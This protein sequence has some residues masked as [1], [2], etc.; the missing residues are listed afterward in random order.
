MKEMIVGFTGT[1]QGMTDEQKEKLKQF[2]LSFPPSELHHGDCIGA[3]NDAHLI[4]SELSIPVV[5]HP[6]KNA[7]K[8]AFTN[9]YSKL[10][11]KKPYLERNHDIVDECNVLF[12]CPKSS[13]E[14]LRSG[15]WATIRY[16][17][18]QQKEIIII[19]PDGMWVGY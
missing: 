7:T 16:A 8:R 9:G 18:K 1:Q 12:A 5:V 13:K 19:Y 4:A 2:F 11:N 3:D 14:Q 15:T 10:L 6:P 17:K